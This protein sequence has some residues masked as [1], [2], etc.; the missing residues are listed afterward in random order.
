MKKAIFFDLDDTLY[1][2]QDSNAKI[3]SEIEA[4]SYFCRKYPQHRF[5]EA[6]AL[7]NAAKKSVK[8]R[9][10]CYPARDNRELW[11]LEFIQKEKIFDK[12]LIQEMEELYWQH[13]F[14]NAQLYYDAFLIL[15]YLHKKY[16]LGII[17]NG[18]KA[19][20][21]KKIYALGIAS[22][23]SIIATSS[24]A[25]F[26]KPHTDVFR[27]ALRKAKVKAKDAVMIGDNPFFDIFPANKLHMTTIWLRRGQRYYYPVIGKTKPMHTITNFL[28]L[29]KWL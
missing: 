16:T 14:K 10:A 12:K 26:D 2:Y 3:K 27:L 19:V 11:F 1:P 4:I 15:P 25:G 9:F 18:L 17:T 24:E 8:N 22:Y 23:F 20:Q 13:V 21:E 28:E 6:L 5:L 29:K 7:Y